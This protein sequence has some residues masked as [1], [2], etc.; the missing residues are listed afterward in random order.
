MSVIVTT[1]LDNKVVVIDY[2]GHVSFNN[3]LEGSILSI[4]YLESTKTLVVNTNEA[5]RHY[6]LPEMTLLHLQPPPSGI[7][8]AATPLV[9]P[10]FVGYISGDESGAIVF[11]KF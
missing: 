4:C 6:R 1:T 5:I 7:C 9:R 2:E 8:R 3:S 11:W 10:D